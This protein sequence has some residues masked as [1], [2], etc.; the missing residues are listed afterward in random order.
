VF[1]LRVHRVRATGRRVSTSTV[2]VSFGPPLVQTVWPRKRALPICA[3]SCS[4]PASC[5]VRMPSAASPVRVPE[6]R[7]RS[8]ARRSRARRLSSADCGLGTI[9]VPAQ[10]REPWSKPAPSGGLDVTTRHLHRRLRL[11]EG[12]VVAR[13]A[14]RS[15]LASFARQASS[16]FLVES[17]HQALPLGCRP[18][19]RHPPTPHEDEVRRRPSVVRRDAM[20]QAQVPRS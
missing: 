11:P 16:G 9:P 1:G 15:A 8:R 2:R 10:P 5:R 4:A 12:T 13:C 18:P 14:A 6:G 20:H 19:S 3:S 7:S 17:S